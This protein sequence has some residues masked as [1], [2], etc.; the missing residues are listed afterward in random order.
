M[1]IR[2][3]YIAASD[4]ILEIVD[5]SHLHLELA[6]FEKDILKIKVGQKIKFTVPEASKEIFDADVHFCLLYTSRC[7]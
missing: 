5:T 2:D 1:C 4:V 6:V 3:R 7:V